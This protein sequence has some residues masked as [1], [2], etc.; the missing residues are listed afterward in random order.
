M[1]EDIGIVKKIEGM[2]ATV[3]VEKKDLCE[4]CAGGDSC[5]STKEGMEIE[6]LNSVRAEVGQTVRVS[7]KPFTYLKG[8]MLLF[9]MPVVFFIAG[10]IAGKLLGEEYLKQFDSDILA[11]IAGFSL[12][13]I[14]IFGL[15]YWSRN[16]GSRE[17]FKPFIEE[18]I[19]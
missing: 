16:A 9:G 6:A 7:M 1:V 3:I 18:I 17:E 5:E 11:A 8:S 19:K 15:K 2:T 12:L 4:D 13:V 14:S 10:T